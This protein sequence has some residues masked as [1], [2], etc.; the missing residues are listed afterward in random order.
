MLLVSVLIR[1]IVIMVA[2]A[3]AAP[4]AVPRISKSV[5]TLHAK[6]AYV[7]PPSANEELYVYKY[8]SPKGV[9]KPNN[10]ELDEVEVPVTDLRTVRGIPFDIVQHGFQLETFQV[11]A[12]INWENDED[13]SA[14]CAAIRRHAAHAIIVPATSACRHSFPFFMA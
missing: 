2:Q 1:S 3:F 13:V 11:P 8:E 7:K 6:V 4:K 12:G 5:P 14:S 9:D 10:L